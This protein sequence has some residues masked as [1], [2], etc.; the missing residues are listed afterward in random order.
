MLFRGMVDRAWMIAYG[1][2]SPLP[3]GERIQVR[4]IDRPIGHL[5][6]QTPI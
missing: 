1:G 2:R 5:T 6:G 3:V 4:G